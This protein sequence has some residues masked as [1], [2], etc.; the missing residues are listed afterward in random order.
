MPQSCPLAFRQIDGTIAR[1]NAMSVFLLSLL[2][3]FIP[4]PLILLVLGFDFMIRLYGNRRFSPVFQVSTLLQRV[5]GL[6]S[7]MVD[8]GAKRL[9]SHFGLFFVFAALVSHLAGLTEVMYAIVAV[10]LFCLSLELLFGY[11]IGCKIYF[12]YRKFVPE[13]R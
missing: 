10:F 2:S 4:E 3:V 5:L 11:C 7:E 8:A 1:I 13:R 9:A 12:I 6:K